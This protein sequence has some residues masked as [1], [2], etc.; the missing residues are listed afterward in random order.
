MSKKKSA[1]I[2]SIQ[3]PFFAERMDSV[4]FELDSCMQNP[5]AFR[6]STSTN[7]LQVSIPAP[8]KYA[9]KLLSLLSKCHPQPDE[10]LR[11]HVSPKA[12]PH[13]PRHES[14]ISS[15]A[16]SPVTLEPQVYTGTE[17]AP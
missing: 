12:C 17:R 3:K 9:A 1:E 7:E 8:L 13:M 10:L 5:R 2:Q 16:S 14:G 15:I 4:K 6:G 11:H